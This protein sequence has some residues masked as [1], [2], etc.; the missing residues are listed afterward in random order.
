MLDQLP[1]LYVHVPFCSAICPYCD[2]AVRVGGAQQGAAFVTALEREV[3]L[4]TQSPTAAWQRGFTTVYLGGGTPSALRPDQ[5]ERVVRALRALP[6]R[7]DAA[8]FLEANPE[9]VDRERLAA[10]KALE[11][12]FLSLGIQ[13][14]VDA[15]LAF[16]GRRH[17]ARQAR[18]SVELALAAGFAVVSLDL[19]YGLPGQQLPAWQHSLEVVAQLLPQHLSC[20]ELEIHA[21][22][23]FGR[24]H[25]RGELLPLSNEHQA[26][27]FGFTHR[28]LQEAGFA[29][30]EVS[31]FARDLRWRSRHNQKYWHHVPYLGLGPAAHSFDGQRRFW[32]EAQFPRWQQQLAR[33]VL[34]P[35]GEE[36]LS[37]ADRALETLMLGLRTP[38]GLGLTAW[39]ESFGTDL[40]VSN[41]AVLERA[42]VAGFLRL[43]DDRLLPTLTG[44]AMADALAAAFTLPEDRTRELRVD[45]ARR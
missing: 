3:A 6:V 45:A 7:P 5:L 11:V 27:F 31:N 8:L 25:A 2:F 42:Q 35:A 13:S 34:A 44:M 17:T 14:F 28:F 21:R 37:R 12:D 22:T 39:R 24:R 9:D 20:Y 19:I 4:W 15:E 32:N 10:W 36:T 43:V 26:E 1:G 33:G 41:R 38:D 16:L 23:P 40:R 18:T 29:A 30:Y